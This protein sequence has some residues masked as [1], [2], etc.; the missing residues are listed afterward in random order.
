MSIPRSHVLD[1]VRGAY[2]D[3]LLNVWPKWMGMAADM[4][5]LAIISPT[6]SNR[7]GTACESNHMVVQAVKLQADQT[8]ISGTSA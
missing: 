7:T 8:A 1:A 4:K 5:S 3:Q 2:R 6:R